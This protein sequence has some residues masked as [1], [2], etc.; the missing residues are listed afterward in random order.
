MRH[1]PSPL[2]SY[3]RPRVLN[4]LVLG[5]AVWTAACVTINV[6]FPEAAVKDLS[7][8]IEDA[9]AEEAEK[10]TQQSE[11]ESMSSVGS[12][13]EVVVID[14]RTGLRDAAEQTIGTI[15]HFLAP[16]P[17]YAAD[18]TVAA[19]EISNPAIRKI[20][21]SRGKRA[22]ELRQLKT[23]GILG[24]NNQALVEIRQLGDLGLKDRAAAQKL[25]K[26]END[27]RQRMFKEVAAAT[28]TDL[29]QLPQIQSTYADTLRRKALAGD[30]IQ[31]ADGT[32]KQKG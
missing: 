31:Q 18:D 27:D 8:Q 17:V 1:H 26:A 9:V 2:P 4:G 22:P 23:Q 28:G 32:W 15:L 25:V 3:H 14:H 5:L 11:A 6:Y 20:I 13:D 10:A 19:P 21:E 30:W 16:S 24:E 29:S 12:V 7:Q